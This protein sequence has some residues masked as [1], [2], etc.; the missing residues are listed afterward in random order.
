MILIR[1][2]SLETPNVWGLSSFHPN[3]S[4]ANKTPNI[5]VLSAV[6]KRWGEKKTN[7]KHWGFL[8]YYPF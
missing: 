6:S 3:V 7:P 5:G 2:N 4:T 1:G 8:D